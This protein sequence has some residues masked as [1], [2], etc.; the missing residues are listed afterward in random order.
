MYIVLDISCPVASGVFG[1]AFSLG[2]VLGRLYG[3]ILRQIGWYF[4]IELIRYEGIYAIVGA[5]ALSGAMTKSVYVAMIVFEMT[6]QLNHLIPVLIGTGVSYFAATPITM[7]FFD[8]MLEFKN[9]PY[10]PS[11]GSVKAYY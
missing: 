4:G 2:A 6:G 3:Q 7:S 5:T 1:P 9:L 10:L 11:L 8:V